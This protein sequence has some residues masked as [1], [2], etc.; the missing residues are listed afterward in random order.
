MKRIVLYCLFAV[1]FLA[2]NAQQYESDLQ[3]DTLL[4][5]LHDAINVQKDIEIQEIK[6]VYRITPWH[7]VPSLNYDFVSN[8]YYITISSG[9]FVT[10]MIN[11]RQEKRRISAI[12]R[13]YNNQI[14]SQETKLKLLFFTLNQKIA[15]IQLS[16][17]ILL[18]DVEIYKIQIQ[19][20]TNNEIDTETFLKE[21]SAILNKIKNHNKE[22][23]DIQNY[24]YEIEQ[25]TEFE[26][27][28]DVLQFYVSPLSINPSKPL[29]P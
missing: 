6:G 16:R 1:S 13:R 27:N 18:N 26:T 12:E 17:E 3:F 22:I 2:T 9:P 15:N 8:R 4:I 20:H 28:I 19:E 24:L 29:K 10:N 21:K 14:K 25:L 5:K 7:F 23:S 11:K